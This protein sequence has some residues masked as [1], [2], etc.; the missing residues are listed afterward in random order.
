MSFAHPQILW[1]LPLVVAV[2]VLFYWWAWRRRQQL[3][4]QFIQSRLLPGLTSGVS[5]GRRK[6]RAGLFLGA[7]CGLIFA[8]ARPQWGFVWEEARIRGLDIVVAIDTSRSML[9]EDIKPNRLARAKLAALD[10]MQQARSDRLGVVAFAGTAY[11][12]CP[13]TIDDAAFRQ[14]VE[15]L[16]TTSLPEGGT[17]LA[18]AIETALT[19][20]K[21]G[22][23]LRVLV[24]FT[25]GDDNAD[26][27]A[28]VAAAA[29]AAHAGMRIYTIG[30]GSAEGE[31]L[32]IRDERGRVD[33]VRDEKGEIVVSRLNEELLSEIAR[34][35][36]GGFFLPLRGA[37]TVET[38]YQNWL[39]RLPKTEHQEKLV[40]RY[41]ERYHWPLAVAILLIASEMMVPERR[42][43]ASRGLT[44]GAGPLA[45]KAGLVVLL[46]APVAA[47]ASSSSALREY[48]AGQY[49]QALKE[50]E[51]LLKKQGDDPRLHFNAGAAAYRNK[52]FGEAVR[53]FEEALNSQ[54]LGLQNS[55]YYNRGNALYY[56]GE[57]AP[58]PKQ[59]T[60]AWKK[61][62][63]DFE[64][65]MKL[66]P[67]DP[68]AK[69]NHDFV[70]KRLEELQQQQSKSQQ[71]QSDKNQEQNKDQ[72]K[73]SKSDSS[74]KD[75]EQQD[76]Q[77]SQQ[78]QKQ[79]QE[80]QKS[81]QG[82]QS[83]PKDQQQ[84]GA[85]EQQ[86][87]QDQPQNAQGNPAQ[88]DPGQNQKEEQAQ[89]GQMTQQQAKQLLDSVKGDEKM[90]SPA[91]KGRKSNDNRPVRDW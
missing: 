40:K 49:D 24:M 38:L 72:Q 41:K 30:I 90:L 60:E 87:N 2:L 88:E 61:S 1:L 59:R 85:K 11:L 89:P 84:A 78:Q 16:T 32:R 74:P 36:E 81:Q 50:Y 37:K 62:I 44:V 6:V 27:Q 21:E 22:E 71:N 69:F 79:E 82:Q 52:Q 64:S 7:V 34:A 86:D 43:K 53:Q 58:D 70:K 3:M 80:Q 4:T 54:D 45:A 42:R 20:F 55:A 76:Q 25:D 33:Y 12:Q 18:D 15:A 29:K 46:L 48:K 57:G 19:A 65:S 91:P 9:A 28:A 47:S 77:D 35:T 66:N 5:P 75:N 10:L 8:L 56:L 67:N 63:Q 17:D 39:S 26:R 83:Q 23:N 51:A 31:Q 68:D 73:Q 14:S 13:L